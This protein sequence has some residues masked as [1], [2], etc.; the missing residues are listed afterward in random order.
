MKL[1]LVPARTGWLWFREG[2]RTFW[3]RPL[4]MTGL[5]FLYV[6]VVSIVGL[7]PIVGVLL[8]LA[9]VPAATLGMMA[10]SREVVEGR[11]PMPAILLSA[12]RA[13]RQRAR[14]MAVLG[15]LYT[16]CFLVILGLSALLDGGQLVR[17]FFLGGELSA[18]VLNSSG[19]QNAVRL[20]MVLYV[21]LSMLFW[22]A[23]ALVHWHGIAPLQSLFYSAV[24][25]TRNFW[26][27]TVYTLAWTVLIFTV[28]LL[29]LATAL[30]VGSATL[31][32]AL[33]LPMAMVMAAMFFTSIWFTFRD[34]YIA[35]EPEDA[36]E[37]APPA[38]A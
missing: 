6:S 31:M 29:V 20:G 16:L 8:S 2:L 35:D 18:D 11:F 19:F 23:P 9:I 3:R 33:T 38:Q 21:P 7:I 27:F 5:F 14:A 10:A 36:P 4:A 12:W 32:A 15:G 34:S 13:G 25:C 24:A 22:F 17:M 1:N 28:T 37:D 26:A 30:S